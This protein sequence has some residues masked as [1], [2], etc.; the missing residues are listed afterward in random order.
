MI[1]RS[2]GIFWD[3]LDDIIDIEDGAMVAAQAAVDEL[4]VE[5]CDHIHT[6]LLDLVMIVAPSDTGAMCIDGEFVR[7]VRDHVRMIGDTAP[8]HGR[9]EVGAI[10]EVMDE[11]LCSIEEPARMRRVLIAGTS[12]LAMLVGRDVLCSRRARPDYALALRVMGNLT[13]PDLV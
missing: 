1:E 11:A 2:P 7:Q 5:F 6:A 8:C 3:D 9:A 10:A 4:E 12:L 13:A